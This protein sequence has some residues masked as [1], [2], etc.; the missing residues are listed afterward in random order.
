[1]SAVQVH[2]ITNGGV[3]TYRWLCDGHKAARVAAKWTVKVGMPL[4]DGS[5]CGDCVVAEQA[6]PGYVTPKWNEVS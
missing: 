6:A 2:E 5:R 4:P 1:M 3:T